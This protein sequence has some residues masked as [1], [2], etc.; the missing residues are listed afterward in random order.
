M[1]IKPLKVLIVAPHWVG[2][3]VMSLGLLQQLIDTH[4]KCELSVL[5]NKTVA[6]VY[7][8]SPAVKDVIEAPFAHG[9]L[10]LGLRWRIGML[11]RKHHFDVAYV[12]PNSFKTALIPFFARIPVRIAYGGQGRSA[13]LTRA[14]PKPNKHHKPPMLDWYGKLCNEWHNSTKLP[15]LR[16]EPD[17]INAIG[18]RW[19]VVGKYLAVAPGAEYGSAKRWPPQYFAQVIESILTKKLLGITDVVL[20][21]GPKDV[22]AA[23]QLHAALNADHQPHVHI[24][25]AQTSLDDAIACVAGATLVLTNDSGLMH[26]AAALNKPLHAIFGSSDPQHT[27]PLTTHAVVHYLGLECSPCFARECPLGHTRCLN[28][29]KPETIVQHL[30]AANRQS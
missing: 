18:Q 29:L 8:S 2:D 16:V 9:H 19:C 28:D 12:L 1:L 27:P 11:L 6:A 20:L 7:Q 26:V 3:A 14:L 24:L 23:Q 25:V 30:E 5:C 10:Q 17:R 13:L 4:P 21:G 15:T 22:H